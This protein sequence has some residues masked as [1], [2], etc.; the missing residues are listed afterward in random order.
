MGMYDDIRCRYPLPVGDLPVWVTPEHNFQT[1]DLECALWQF[2]ITEDGRLVQTYPE[3]P[4]AAWADFHGDLE[5]YT[6]NIV[7]STK[8]GKLYVEDGTGDTATWLAFVARF[9]DGKVVHIR[10][11]ERTDEPAQPRSAFAREP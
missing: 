5:F 8:E 1:K 10:L 6:S 3:G 4:V 2:E 11:T 7:I 9:T